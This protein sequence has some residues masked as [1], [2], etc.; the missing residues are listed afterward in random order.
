M[1][2][3]PIVVYG[4]ECVTSGGIDGSGSN[5]MSNGR[6]L[7]SDGRCSIGSTVNFDEGRMYPAVESAGVRT[8]G[9]PFR[10]LL[11][12]PILHIRLH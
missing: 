5:A 1:M 10:M 2:S 12:A 9:R 11:C 4:H 8:E 7:G 3:V 6:A